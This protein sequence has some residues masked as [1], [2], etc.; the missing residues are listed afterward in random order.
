M[1]MKIASCRRRC[2]LFGVDLS[3]R[4]SVVGKLVADTV[5]N[6]VLVIGELTRLA[7]ELSLL[8]LASSLLLNLLLVGY[9]CIVALRTL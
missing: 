8:Q 6:V 9:L 4:G 5:G 7:R 1:E 3:E 2:L